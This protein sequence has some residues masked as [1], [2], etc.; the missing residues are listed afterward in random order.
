MIWKDKVNFL[1]LLIADQQLIADCDCKQSFSSMTHPNP[2][3]GPSRFD[4]NLIDDSFLST[5]SQCE[6]RSISGFVD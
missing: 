3:E 1:V 2:F 4:F 5:N 6:D